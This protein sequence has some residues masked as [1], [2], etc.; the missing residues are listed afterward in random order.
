VTG[1]EITDYEQKVKNSWVYSELRESRNFKNGFD[2]G[3]WGGLA[4]GAFT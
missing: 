4:H 1:M 2:K 3:L